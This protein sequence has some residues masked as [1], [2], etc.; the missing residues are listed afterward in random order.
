MD[1]DLPPLH[2]ASSDQRKL[3]TLD[4]FRAAFPTE[5]DHLEFKSSGSKDPLQ[6]ALVAFSN[7]DG[8]VIL[9]GISDQGELAGKTNRARSWIDD[10]HQAAGDARD[11]GRYEVKRLKVDSHDILAVCVQ[12]RARG[13]AQT[14][15]G[16]ILQRR[17]RRNIPLYGAD[18][19]SFLLTRTLDR[20]ERQPSGF[21]LAD[22][23]DN[24]LQDLCAAQSW[25]TEATDLTDRLRGRG[26]VMDAPSEELTIAGAMF[27]VPRHDRKLGKTFVEILRYPGDNM[28]TDRRLLIRGTLPDQVRDVTRFVHDEL[29]LD[30]V[31]SGLYR[32]EL[33]K[34][35]E[36]VI[37][38]AVA[39]AIA[40]RSY[41]AN[42][43]PIRIELRPSEVV[44]TSPGGLIEP[45][46]EENIRETNAARN[47]IVI[48]LLRDFR[49]A[50]DQG[51]GVDLMQDKMSDA[52][53]DPPRFRDQV[54]AVEV[55][56]P[57]HS[58]IAPS[59]RA[60]VMEVER[61]GR[62][63]P[64]DRLLLV[65]AAR[66]ERL[67]NRRVREVLHVDN[68]QARAA[69]RRL[70]EAGLLQKHGERA[71][72]YYEV[73]TAVRPPAAFRMSIDDLCNLIVEAAVSEPLSNQ[74][75]RDLTGLD[76]A[77][78]LR[79]LDFLTASGRLRRIGERRGTR[80]LLNN[81]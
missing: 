68:L 37:R 48:D 58:P 20:F 60:W 73:D 80:Y 5:T 43:T 64:N 32:Y 36:E 74:S 35:P 26:L 23:D 50:E 41:E 3:Y 12:R 78:A 1:A 52:L 39:N 28:P 14:S 47:V 62:L 51:L 15:S 8:G 75:V 67:T 69:L 65:H 4:E 63:E 24:C 2:P 40:H 45:V 38:E 7:T 30:S 29:G 33:P 9:V 19:T 49:L 53:L 27:L 46:T 21:T 42:G 79:L 66:G 70:V 71:G 16:V 72:S 77:D 22:V 10:V 81:E 54:H 57:V 17:G 56:L 18:L 61:Q 76:R 25:R 59:E 6:K 34:L 11:V 55:T 31:V 44:I 13:F